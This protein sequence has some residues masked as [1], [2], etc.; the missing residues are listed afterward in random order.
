M[1]VCAPVALLLGCTRL[2]GGVALPAVAPGAPDDTVD[3][4][5]IMLGPPRIRALVGADEQLTI[6]PT[7]DSAAPVDIDEL[8][9]TIPPPCRFIF[10]ETKVFGSRATRFHKTTY[11]YPPKGALLSEGAAV[12]PDPESARGALDALVGAVAECADSPA[13]PELV[14]DW[15]ADDGTVRTHA[16]ACGRGYQVKSVVLLEVTY[17]GFSGGDAELILSN[18]AAAVPG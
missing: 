6:I 3:P 7:M 12:Y 9:A 13:G 4:G 14:G 18:M 2:I 1:L 11:Q 8:A 15:A 17:C 16:G 5:R 10:A